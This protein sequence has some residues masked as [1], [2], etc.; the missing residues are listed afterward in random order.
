MSSKDG[1]TTTRTEQLKSHLYQQV[2]QHIVFD[3][4]DRPILVFTAPIDTRDGGPCTV[5]EYL[6]RGGISTQVQ[7]RQEREYRWKA[8]WDQNF[9]FDPAVDYDADGDGNI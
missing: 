9:V 6:Y 4:Q 7:A 5:T 1:V 3:A 8:V 2:K